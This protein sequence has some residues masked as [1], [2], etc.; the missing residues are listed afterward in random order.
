VVSTIVVSP[1]APSSARKPAHGLLADHVQA[2]GGLVEK[3]DFG[4]VQQ[5]RGQFPAHPLSQGQLPHGNV[6]KG[7]HVEQVPAPP[8]AGSVFEGVDPI[9]VPQQVKRV[10]QRQIP[11]QLSSVSKHDTDAAREFDALRDRRQPAHAHGAARRR[12][13]TGQHLER[14]GLARAVGAQISHHLTPLDHE[15]DAVDRGHNALL[16][17][18]HALSHAHVELLAQSRSFDDLHDPVLL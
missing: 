14:G 16:A 9:D 17:A 7:I 10:A 11:P 1:R 6:Q 13:H 3:E 4:A 2:D 8:K 5:G 18:Q 12:E 15:V